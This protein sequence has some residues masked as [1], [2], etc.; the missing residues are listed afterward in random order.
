[1]GRAVDSG[2]SDDNPEV[3]KKRIEVYHELTKP[4]IQFY[5]ERNLLES[6]SGM[7]SIDEVASRIDQ[8]IQKKMGK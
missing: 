5:E 3:I 4:V 2:R 1:M 6:V 7:A 8:I